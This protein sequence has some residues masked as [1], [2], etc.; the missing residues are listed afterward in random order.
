MAYLTVSEP[1]LNPWVLDHPLSY[2]PGNGPAVELSLAFTYR[3]AQSQISLEWGHGGSPGL[4][5]FGSWFS[6]A[7]LDSSGNSA[8]V[9]LPAGGFALFTFSGST[10]SVVNYR[11]NWILQKVMSSGTVAS[12]KLISPSGKVIEYG[13]KVS[14][15]GYYLYYMTKEYDQG[16]NYTLFQYDAND[17]LTNVVASDS[18][19]FSLA[20]DG[21]YTTLITNVVASYGATVALIHGETDLDSEDPTS[22]TTIV[23]PVGI[24]SRFGFHPSFNEVLNRIVTP[25]GTTQF[26]INPED[27]YTTPNMPDRIVW[28]THPNEGVEV[29]ASLNEGSGSLSAWPAFDSGEIPSGTPIGTIDS[30]ER[31]DR[32]TFHWSI[33]AFEGLEST[34]FLDLTWTQFKRARIRHWLTSTTDLYTHF[35]TLSWEQAPSPDGGTTAGQVTWYDYAGKPSDI[36]I[37]TQVMP[38]VVA[39]V[40]PDDT[41]WYKYWTRNSIGNP[42]QE[43]EKWVDNS[44][45]YYRTNSWSYSADGVDVIEHRFGPSGGDKL[46]SGFGYDGSHPH[47]PTSVTNALNEVSTTTYDT[48]HR[49]VTHTTA[50]GMVSSNSYG[51]DGFL[52]KTVVYESGIGPVSTNAY[53]WS[54]GRILTQTDP[55]GLTVTNTWDYLGRITK[56]EYPD[57]SSETFGYT[58]SAGVAILDVTSYTNRLGF[59]NGYTYN[60]FR[61]ILTNYDARGVITALGYCDCGTLVTK[62]NAYG[63]L[64]ETSNYVYDYQGR[65]LEAYRPDGSSRTNLYDLLGRLVIVQDALGA[66]TNYYD[67]LNRIVLSSNAFGQTLAISYDLEDNVTS[68]ADANGVTVTSTYDDLD[69][70]RT[71]TF[72]DGG[73]EAFGYTAT[74]SG[75]TS[76]TNQLA[77][78]TTYA[79]DKLGR[80]TTEIV[81]GLATNTFTYGPASDL[82]TLSDG[83]SQATTW[84]YTI[85]GQVSSKQYANNSTGLT[86][87]YDA[88]GRLTNRWSSAKGNTKYS[89]DANGNLTGIDYPTS[90]DVTIQYDDLNRPTSEAVSGLFTSAYTYHPGGAVATEDGPWS[91]DTLSYHYNTAGLRDG[92]TIQQPAGSFTNGYSYDAAHRLTQIVSHSGTYTYD[93]YPTN[94]GFTAATH[95][96]R[97]LTLPPGSYIT[98]SFDNNARELETTL[99]TS[100]DAELNDHAY[101]YNVGNRRTKQTYTDNSYVTY[102]Y[103]DAGELRTAYTTNSS[104]AEITAQR[105]M[106]GYDAAW[107]MTKRTNSAAVSTYTVNNLNQVTADSGNATSQTYDSNGNRVTQPTSNGTEIFTYDS[108][109]RLIEFYKDPATFSSPPRMEFKY[110]ARGRLRER[111]DST[112]DNDIFDWVETGRTRYI[113]DGML[114]VQERT[115]SNVPQVAYTR[116]TDFSGTFQGAGGIGGLLARSTSY[117]S[118]S[119]AWNTHQFYHADGNGNITYLMSSAQ[120]LAASYRYDPFGRTIT[121]SGG[122]ASANTMRFSSKQIH[123]NSL[124]FSKLYYYGYRFYDPNTQRW[125]NRDPLYDGGSGVL[126]EFGIKRRFVVKES[127]QEPNSYRFA[128]NQPTRY[129]DVLGLGCGAQNAPFYKGGDSGVPDR[130]FGFDFGDACETHDNCYGKCGSNKDAC[131]GQFYNNLKSGC[132]GLGPD[133]AMCLILAEIYYQAVHQGGQGAFDAAQTE[134]CKDCPPKSDNGKRPPGEEWLAP[135]V[136]GRTGVR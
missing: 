63:S 13:R 98:N 50:S 103:D 122:S 64:N 52:A 33:R 16:G 102:T 96:I 76:Y 107:N 70:V 92:L 35:D 86:Y 43:I 62:T 4:G 27:F 58:T 48:A 60:C 32:N 87:A 131:D 121:S 110:D 45:T 106:Y 101:V 1:H 21:S 29:Y 28:I 93:Y 24:V 65:L 85:Y 3:R 84:G 74:V 38:S 67:N 34:G 36:E 72:P 25:Y 23:D 9:L 40:M 69:R 47:L 123:E 95:L 14:P 108:E 26:E 77:K 46:I 113:Y 97:K 125:L 20:Y 115:S 105:Y 68:R 112:W 116:G 89:Y 42:T 41:T 19:S 61:Q 109:N 124:L 18:V 39:R 54:N 80:K 81:V 117:Q 127:E 90:P 134:A 111:I 132:Q 99:N 56:R 104:G 17:L 49:I 128:R 136:P 22:L 126:A 11:G 31:M 91:S 79:Y 78:V 133:A 100:A 120:A 119:G 5:W 73:V 94:G 66:A 53:T 82:L 83:K 7:E 57:S 59:T 15:G 129:W 44:T 75:P 2:Q 30:D 135:G 130:P 37:G 71:R 55:R 118:G 88:S 12:M 8:E 10:N 6:W 51:G 114:L